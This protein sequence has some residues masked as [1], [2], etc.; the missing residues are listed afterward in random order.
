MPPGICP[1]AVRRW[2]QILAY[3]R[4]V[5]FGVRLCPVAA[6]AVVAT[7]ADI[8]VCTS[9]VFVFACAV[10]RI[11]DLVDAFIVFATDIVD[12]GSEKNSFLLVGHILLS[13]G[14]DEAVDSRELLFVHDGIDYSGT[15]P[16]CR[17][18]LSLFSSS[19]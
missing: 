11:L 6:S 9:V 15:F 2:K 1:E 8:I 12:V 17:Y 4:F 3:G 19:V 5:A 13:E 14:I 16:G 18:L 7:C 10:A